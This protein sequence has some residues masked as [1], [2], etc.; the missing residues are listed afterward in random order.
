MTGTE[1]G[2]DTHATRAA[3]EPLLT[4][5]AFSRGVFAVDGRRVNV[6][7]AALTWPSVNQA[8]AIATP[9]L[10]LLPGRTRCTGEGRHVSGGQWSR[11]KDG[12]NQ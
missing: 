12:E 10:P 2:D 1:G 3:V 9:P 11:G 5:A 4:D 6:P 8:A 7:A